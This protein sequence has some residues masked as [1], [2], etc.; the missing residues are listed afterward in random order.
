MDKLDSA[1]G[2]LRGVLADKPYSD[3]KN[4]YEKYLKLLDVITL[5]SSAEKFGTPQYVLN[6][7]ELRA[8]A[9]LFIDTFRKYIPDLEAFYAF[10]CNDFPFLVESL[11]E[12]GL[13][14]DVAGL[15]ELQLALKLGF[16]KIIFTGPGKSAEEL[17]L[18]IQNSDKVIIN[19]DNEDEFLR[20]KSLGPKKRVNVSIRI[21]PDIKITKVW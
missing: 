20:L 4:A 19:L 18:S 11:K 13:K 14:A 21:N 15:F 10:K 1:L 16:D 9:R 8:R 7:G 3:N 2:I 5:A 12:E 17:E 6:A